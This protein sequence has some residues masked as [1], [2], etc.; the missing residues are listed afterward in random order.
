MYNNWKRTRK[1][2]AEQRHGVMECAGR[3]KKALHAESIGTPCFTKTI[4]KRDARHSRVPP[5]FGLKSPGQAT[6]PFARHYRVRSQEWTACVASIRS[7]QLAIPPIFTTF[8]YPI[9]TRNAQA[10]AL[11]APLR[12]YTNSFV[13]RSGTAFSISP[14]RLSGMLRLPGM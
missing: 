1:R 3:K 7:R 5:R 4:S 6:R 13:P 8:V 2:A 12:Q 10:L 9:R 11:R 14:M